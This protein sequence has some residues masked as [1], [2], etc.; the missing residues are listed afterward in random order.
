[1]TK[2]GTV[3]TVS[4]MEIPPV[5]RYVTGFQ[6]GAKASKPDVK[7]LNTYIPSFVDSAKGKETGAAMLGQGCD[8]VFGVGGITGN[9][10]LLAANQ[11]GKMAIGVDVDQYLT[12]PEV[13][14]SLLTS[15]MKNVDVAVYNAVKDFQAGNLKPG[16]I[17]A[18]IKNGGVGLAG[19]HDWESKIDQKCKDA[20][21]KATDDLKTGKVS[22]R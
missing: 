6:N 17:T 21:A 18:T 8:V 7:T 11:A 12:Y 10:G 4:G 2:T 3:C 9:G 19:Y 13:K 5:V 16:I 14:S 20:V 1:M 15:A 22:T